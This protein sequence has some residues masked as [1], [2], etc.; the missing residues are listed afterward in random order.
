MSVSRKIFIG[1]L[2]AAASTGRASAQARI[3]LRVGCVP[4][5]SFAQAYFAREMGFFQRAGFDV[6][7]T[8]FTNGS[9]SAN[10]IAG[11]AI[12]I[13]ISTVTAMANATIHG[14]PLSYFAGGALFDGKPTTALL[15]GKSSPITG[16]KDFIG[17]TVAVSG[18]KDGT[19][20]PLVVWLTKNG[21]DPATVSVIEMPFSSMTSA[22]A[23]GTIAGAVCSEPAITAGADN[24]R[25]LAMVH[26]AVAATFMTG[27]WFSS[28]TWLKANAPVARRFANVIYET[29]RWANANHER[30][31]DI[32]EKY[33]KIDPRVLG[34]MTRV[35]FAEK[36]T[37]DL[38]APSLDW[39]FRMKFLER[40][41]LPSEMITIV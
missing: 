17:K 18:L 39:G 6:D 37:P 25:V 15:V 24:A 8:T 13:G 22:I 1:A 2:T 10:A 16:A 20:L 7:I 19:H 34:K 9:G 11:G 31:A 38:I 41:V 29:A 3:P 5:D 33:A 26:E 23:R 35:D 30:T 21:V 12:D 32:I 27:G 14:V 4:V 40:R 36:L 28:K